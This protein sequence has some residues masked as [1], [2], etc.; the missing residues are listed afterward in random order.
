MNTMRPGRRPGRR[1]DAV[2]AWLGRALLAGALYHLAARLALELPYLG[3][4]VSLLWLPAGVALAACLRGGLS[5]AVPVGLAAAV[6]NWSLAGDP[7]VA[8]GIG[9]G[10]AAGPMAGAWALRRMR[11]DRHLL[12]RRDLGSLLL[13][14]AGGAALSASNGVAWLRV[15]GLPPV[16]TAS[17]WL[18]WWVGDSVGGLI[19]AAP[20]MAWDLRGWREAM[21]A[22]P[23]PVRLAMLLAAAAAAAL[24]F[25]GRVPA[26]SPLVFALLA[27]PLCAGAAL[28]LGSGLLLLSTCTLTV[29]AIAAAGTA[30][31]Q[32]PFAGQG[33]QAGPLALWSFLAAQAASGLLLWVL[34]AELQAARRQYEA[35][36]A[37]GDIGIILLGEGRVQALNPAAAALLAADPVGRV[38]TPAGPGADGGGRLADLAGGD[39]LQ[40]WLDGPAAGPGAAADGTELRLGE[41]TV[42]A[43]VAR[44]QDP[45]GRPAAQLLLH[46]VSAQ[47]A[48]ERQVARSEHQLRTIT[49]HLPALVAYID[50]D[51]RFRFAN[52]AYRDWLGLEPADMMG[53]TVEDVLGPH[54]R[55][56]RQAPL[57]AALAGQRSSYE[58]SIGQGDRLRHLRGDYV[59]DMGPDGQVLGFFAL[60]MDVT[61]LKKV[62]F[63][64]D[65]LARYDH[66]T[67]VL[68]RQEFERRLDEALAAARRHLSPLALLFIDVD[69]F[70]AI[71][72]RHGHA[73]GDRALQAVTRRVQQQVRGGDLVGRLAGD[74]F[75]VLLDRP[76]APEGATAVAGKLCQAMHEPLVLEHGAGRVDLRVSIGVAWADGGVPVDAPALLGAAD[77]ALYEAKR[78]GRDTWRLRRCG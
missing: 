27:V 34:A 63:A 10:N 25:S 23:G 31:G 24:V 1:A 70:K 42:Q 30:L 47:R 75:V 67:G 74:E 65:R 39:V 64:L 43:R 9:L 46:D 49:D 15:D 22:R 48:A 32:G 17:A 72:D 45:G 56:V 36:F 29:S 38:G 77:Q 14:L 55:A 66:L 21:S 18:A 78:A 33:Q 37:H 76:H 58:L 26:D 3:T 13:A 61:E 50:R 28:A 69:E 54:A 53:R 7:V 19:A 8:V 68:S 59:P 5:M 60:V 16:Q 20:L 11:F 4:Q 71:N 6:A 35:L 73:A 52:A 44:Y 41:H 40:R 12:R 51:E 62:Q 57:R 2:A